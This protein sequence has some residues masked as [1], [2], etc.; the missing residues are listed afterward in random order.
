M[1]NSAAVGRVPKIHTMA[2]STAVHASSVGYQ[3]NR[4]ANSVAAVPPNT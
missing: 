4:P 1:K 3:R 2:K